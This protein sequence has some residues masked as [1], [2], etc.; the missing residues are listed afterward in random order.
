MAGSAEGKVVLVTGAGGGMGRAGAEIFAREGAR[1]IYVAD[2]KVDGGRETVELVKKAGGAATFVEID[3]TD[4]DAVAG[5]VARIASEHGRLDTAWNNA[6]INDVSRPFHELEKTDWDRMIAVN[7]TSVFFCMKHEVRQMLAQGGGAIVNTSS[8]AG[9]G[10]APGLPH[11]TA[12]KHGVLGLTKC[13]AVEGNEKGIR[14]NAVCPGMIDTPMIQSWFA[15]S[16]DI[17]NMVLQ[18]MPGKRLG[19]PEQVAEV[20]VW[21]CSEAAGWLSGVSVVVDGGASPR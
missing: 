1:H 2:L 19:R 3:V 9:L 17:A 18:S 14:V 16:P 20:A 13:A 7:L 10:P 11:Y 15:S 4:E 8:G 6:G 5:L 12:A 21:L